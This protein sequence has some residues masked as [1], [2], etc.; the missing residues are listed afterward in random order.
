MNAQRDPLYQVH[1]FQAARRGAPP[2]PYADFCTQ[3]PATYETDLSGLLLRPSGVTVEVQITRKPKFHLG[4]MGITAA[5][6]KAVPV[7]EAWQAVARHAAGDWGQV[8]AKVRAANDHALIHG[9]QLASRFETS[10]GQKFYIV[11]DVAREMTTV[12]LPSE[13]CGGR[14]G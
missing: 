14:C 12:M 1:Q 2:L 13:A 4:R 8:E 7:A 3:L 10:T 9:G 11:T 6:A 5:A